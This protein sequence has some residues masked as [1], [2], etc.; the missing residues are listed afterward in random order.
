MLHIL[1]LITAQNRYPEVN[2][3]QEFSTEGIPIQKLLNSIHELVRGDA[4]KV[5][6]GKFNMDFIYI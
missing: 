3:H 2:H 4:L 6:H 5:H 1:S